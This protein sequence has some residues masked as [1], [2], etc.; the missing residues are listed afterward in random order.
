MIK[1][2]VLSLQRPSL[3]DCCSSDEKGD[4]FFFSSGDQ[5][6]QGFLQANLESLRN[7]LSMCDCFQEARRKFH[8]NSV[9]PLELL[10]S[11]EGF[12]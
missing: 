5:M 4:S 6:R 12:K 10:M 1:F 3:T 2:H 7:I 11:S 8:L 9:G